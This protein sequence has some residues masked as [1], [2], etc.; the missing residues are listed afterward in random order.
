MS[1]APT[2]RVRD[3]VLLL[4]EEVKELR[5]QGAREVECPPSAQHHSV[6]TGG[7]GESVIDADEAVELALTEGK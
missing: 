1:Q 5:E 2:H 6:C 7:D 4:A 3:V